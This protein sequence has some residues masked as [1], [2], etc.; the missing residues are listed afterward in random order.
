MNTF[1][2]HYSILLDPP[3]SPKNVNHKSKTY[4]SIIVSWDPP[5]RTERDPALTGYILKIRPK[6]KGGHCKNG[7]C[8]LLNE[9]ARNY[10]IHHLKFG[11]KYTMT[12]SAVNCIG[13]SDDVSIEVQTIAESKSVTKCIVYY[14]NRN[15]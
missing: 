13:R 12:I 5:H 2:C 3:S 9:S 8:P 11:V 10:T 14:D 6:P 7:S 15:R 4:S 1:E